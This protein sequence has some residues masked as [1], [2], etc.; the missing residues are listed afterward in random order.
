MDIKNYFIKDK[1][2]VQK[3]KDEILENILKQQGIYD[4]YF[5]GQINTIQTLINYIDKEYCII[6]LK[7]LIDSNDTSETIKNLS[8]K[9]IEKYNKEP[10][11]ETE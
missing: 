6:I 7:G 11:F 10:K 4:M 2:E 5:L 9:L 3:I 8:K 1:S